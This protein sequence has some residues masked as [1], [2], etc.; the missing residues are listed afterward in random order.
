MLPSLLRRVFGLT[1][2]SPGQ[3]GER[4][5]EK[6]LRSLSYKLIARNLRNRLGEIDLL[7]L[8]P[9]GRTIVFIEVKTAQADRHS[10]IPP[11]L[12]VGKHKQHKIATLAARLIAQHKL[13]GRPVRFDI[14]GVTL[15]ADRAA[16]VRHYPGAFESPW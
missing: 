13:T 12:R 11:E 2:L 7:M 16:E 4:I 14:V 5:A 15:H 9:D 10:N 3:Q 6:Y 8:A 1:P